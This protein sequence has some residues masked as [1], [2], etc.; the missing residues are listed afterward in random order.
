MMGINAGYSRMP[1]NSGGTLTRE[2]KEEIRLELEKLEVIPSLDHPP[3]Q[4]DIKITQA[5]NDVGVTLE[6][7]QDIKLGQGS[8]DTVSVGIAA[9]PKTGSL[10]SAFVKLLTTPKIGHEALTVILEPN[11]PVRPI[12]MMFPVQQ[13]ES[14]RQA[15]LFY[16]PVQAGAAQAVAEMLAAGKVPEAS[17]SDDVVIMSLDV[18]LNARERRTIRSETKDA[19]LL[20]LGQ[21][22]S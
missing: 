17:V 6:D 9:G 19:V 2:L 10:G 5:L 7:A 1:L 14:M 21:I 13:I 8:T 18:D 11:L 15:S 3:I 16:G 12:S 20:A 4:K 22:W